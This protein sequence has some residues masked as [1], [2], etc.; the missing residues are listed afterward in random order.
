MF[1]SQ[2]IVTRGKRKK[3]RNETFVRQV[4]VQIKKNAMKSISSEWKKKIHIVT[5]LSVHIG[6]IIDTVLY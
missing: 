3:A 6:Y 2:K 1:L 5:V 4:N